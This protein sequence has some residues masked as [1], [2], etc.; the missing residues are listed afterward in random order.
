MK[1]ILDHSDR[2]SFASHS[3]Y[4]IKLTRLNLSLTTP[5][6]ERGDIDG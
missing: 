6:L 1:T 5:N 4:K 3:M 2:E